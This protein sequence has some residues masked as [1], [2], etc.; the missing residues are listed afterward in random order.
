MAP[1]PQKVSFRFL[2]FTYLCAILVGV[3]I[4]FLTKAYESGFSGADE[5]SHFLNGYF[6]SDYLVHHFGKNPMAAATDFYLHYPKI[7]IGHWPPAYYGMLGLLFL[8]L[9]P[10]LPVAFGINVMFA[11]L[12]AIG[13]A[14]ALVILDKRR[15]AAVAGVLVYAL[16]PLALE[17][18]AMFMVDQPLAACLVAATAVWIAYALRPTWGK[19]LAFALLAAIAILMKGNG[20]LVGLIPAFH[21]V[22]TTNWKLLLSPKLYAA[23]LLAALIVVPWYLLTAKI[24]ADGFNYHAGIDYASKALFAN[25]RTLSHNL[26][27]AGA[28]LAMVG[29]VAE[30]RSRRSDTVRWTIVSGIVSLPL[31]TLVL[32]STVPVDIT[33]RY[34]APALPAVVV[35]A[36]LGAG[37]FLTQLRQL[38]R[39]QASMAMGATMIAMIAVM[40]IP[41][42]L[43]VSQRTPKADAGLLQVANRL[44][45]P[46]RPTVTVIDGN[47]G[48][49]GAF[50]ADMAVR[51]QQ[52]QGY[53]VRSSKLLADSDFM[54]KAYTLKFKQPGQVVA[55]LHRL[56]VGHV[57]I[58]RA[59][60]RPAYPHS[61]QMREAVSLPDSGFRL[62]QQ[63]QHRFRAGMTEVYD[64][65]DTPQPAIAAVRDLGLPSKAIS[66]TKL[67]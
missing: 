16:T 39:P 24:A 44:A 14:A 29:I 57:V 7:S 6:I 34:M 13:V 48:Y 33:E 21:I 22:L 50:I 51:D 63:I 2:G 41:G 23:A 8:V 9:P 30:Y 20:W 46:D 62:S 43:H 45:A 47:A 67:Q 26:T 4:V 60:N 37:H 5:P 32:Q 58:V 35:L 53:V 56:G 28:L 17:G 15:Y 19:A 65:V 40:A 27:P 11:A 36:V 3:L 61:K 49:E 10:T 59:D 54:G 64:A 31:A 55:E 1:S 25:L 42:I 38:V 52:L 18:D 66:L 12:P